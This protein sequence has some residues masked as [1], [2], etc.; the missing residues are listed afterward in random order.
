MNYKELDTGN[1]FAVGD[2]WIDGGVELILKNK[3]LVFTRRGNFLYFNKR[4][5]TIAS[6][7]YGVFSSNVY[8]KVIK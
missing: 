2:I 6:S 5:E 8:R 1:V 7:G 4:G 3:T